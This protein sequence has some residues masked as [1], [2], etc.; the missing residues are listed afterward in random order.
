M[1]N[2]Y[3][4]KWG[5]QNNYEMYSDKGWEVYTVINKLHKLHNV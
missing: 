1:F 2:A 5:N 4:S 3:V